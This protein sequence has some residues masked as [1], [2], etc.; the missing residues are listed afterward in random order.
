MLVGMLSEG[1]FIDVVHRTI[2]EVMRSRCAGL[3]LN[4]SMHVI[5]QGYGG[6]KFCPCGQSEIRFTPGEIGSESR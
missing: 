4:S 3:I 2:D 6:V 5:A 1:I